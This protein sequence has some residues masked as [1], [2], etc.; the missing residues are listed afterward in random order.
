MNRTVVV[1]W[2]LLPTSSMAGLPVQPTEQQK[3][4]SALEKHT[5]TKVPAPPEANGPLE[6]E[7]RYF[8][9][10]TIRGAVAGGVSVSLAGADSATSTTNELGAFRVNGLPAGLYVVKP[11]LSGHVFRPPVAVATLESGTPGADLTFVATA[12]GCAPP[13]A[14]FRWLGPRA[15]FMSTNARFAADVPDSEPRGIRIYGKNGTWSVRPEGPG[16]YLHCSIGTNGDCREQLIPINFESSTDGNG[17]SVPVDLLEGGGRVSV[18]FSGLQD[19]EGK[20]R[21][22]DAVALEQHHLAVDLGQSFTLNA[23]GSF[24]GG[25]ELS[26]NAYSRWMGALSGEVDVR[27]AQLAQVEEEVGT[28]PGTEP[29]ESFLEKGGNTLDGSVRVLLNLDLD[30]LA[31]TKADSQ[32]WFSVVGGVGLRSMISDGKEV[33]VRRR[34]FGGARLQVLGY[35][36][37]GPAE[38]FTDTRGHIELGVANDTFWRDTRRSRVYAQG[39]LELPGIGSKLVRFLTRATMDRPLSG[40]GPSEVRVSIL[41]TLN[42]AELGKLLGFGPR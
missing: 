34:V 11:T 26:L 24:I 20:V 29:S 37:G 17:S 4:E 39:Q 13:T 35:N 33:D 12:A 40:S 27:M 14:S 18:E 42:P 21:V 15:A 22:A 5:P 10:G 8:I 38:S 2:A 6:E 1:L 41:S 32:P 25:F 28:E 23:R 3:S 30:E 7:K 36:A 19:C 16:K 9:S 31:F